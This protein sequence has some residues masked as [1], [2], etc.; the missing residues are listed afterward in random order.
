MAQA[1]GGRIVLRCGAKNKAKAFPDKP[2]TP[3]LTTVISH[4]D[5]ILAESVVEARTASHLSEADRLAMKTGKVRF[6][7]AGQTLMIPNVFRLTAT[8]DGN[9]QSL[10]EYQDLSRK[11]VLAQNGGLKGRVEGT[12]VAGRKDRKPLPRKRNN[13]K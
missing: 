2:R 10:L 13:T 11:E 12:E 9:N 5:S 1:V 6:F 4:D 7:W 8:I 3:S